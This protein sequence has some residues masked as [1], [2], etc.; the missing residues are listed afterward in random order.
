MTICPVNSLSI[1][2]RPQSTHVNAVL[3]V[4]GDGEP[5]KAL[6]LYCDWMA[7]WAVISDA[8]NRNATGGKEAIGVNVFVS[9]HCGEAN[10]VTQMNADNSDSQFAA[11]SYRR[12]TTR[13]YFPCGYGKQIKL[14]PN[15]NLQK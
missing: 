9:G 4:I 8:N 6:M 14:G 1:R 15:W 3:I 12:L 5:R 10:C 2:R 11:H 13:M 7:P